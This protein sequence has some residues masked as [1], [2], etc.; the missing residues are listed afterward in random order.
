MVAS[1]FISLQVFKG[2]GTSKQEARNVAAEA[3]VLALGLDASQIILFSSRQ[4][5]TSDQKNPNK[6]LDTYTDDH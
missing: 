1:I 2:H 5:F 3:A 4:D 6:G